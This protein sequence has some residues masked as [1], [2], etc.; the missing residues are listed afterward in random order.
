MNIKAFIVSK[1]KEYIRSIVTKDIFCQ[2]A[3]V[4]N[5]GIGLINKHIK[6]LNNQIIIGHRT[7]LY[8]PEFRIVGNNNKIIIND[9]CRIGPNCRFWAEGNNI[10]IIIGEHCTFTNTVHVNAQE[11][12]SSICIGADC[13][14]SN[15]IIVR[16]SDSHPIIDLESETRINP[17]GNVIIGEHVWGA[18]NSKIMKG[19]NIGKNSII[20]SNTIVTKDIPE[21]S[22]AVGM[23]AKV[24]RSKVKWTRDNIINKI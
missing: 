20:G 17:A 14:F 21:D 9:N 18:P 7:R 1:L 10:T 8:Y 13:M 19:V 23:P 6:G 3:K 24:V 16:T 15:H 11:N 12:N 22:I 4:D 5:K 2:H